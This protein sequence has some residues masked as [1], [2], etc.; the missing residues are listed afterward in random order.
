M[1]QPD[2]HLLWCRW[3]PR[4]AAPKPRLEDLL[5]L[6]LPAPEPPPEERAQ[7]CGWFDSSHDLRAGLQ[8]QEHASADAVANELS[9]TAWLDLHLMEAQRRSVP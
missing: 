6:E 8:V 1:L 2:L 5:Q 3:R 7:G 4:P 9:L